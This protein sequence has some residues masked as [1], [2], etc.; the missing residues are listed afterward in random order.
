M[1]M[2]YCTVQEIRDE[3][4]TADQASDTRLTALID[5]ATAYIDGVTKQWFEPRAMTITL[6]GNGS[7]KLFLPVFPIEVSRVTVDGQAI[8]DYIAYNRFFPDDRRNPK[9]VREAGW[10]EGCQNVSIEGT[11]GYVD[12]VGTQY[13]TPAMIK[14]VAKRLVIRELP[15]LGDAEGQEERKRAR[16]VSETTDGHSYTL[17]RLAGTLDLTGDPDIDGV[18]ALFRAP[19]A[20]GGI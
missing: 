15:L 8:T 7:K 20:I 16:I 13:T 1:V 14:Q 3:G 9:I 5:L 6:D 10:P 19:I 18:L 4:I 12:K 2:A 11:W 17:E